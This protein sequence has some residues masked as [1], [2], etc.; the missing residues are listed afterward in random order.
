MKHDV[1]TCDECKIRKRCLSYNRV[2]LCS[3]CT[4]RLV[5]AWSVLAN[6][7]QI[8]GG[9]IMAEARAAAE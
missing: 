7:N 8:A 9:E 6:T 3:S 5:C 2:W 4:R 1:A